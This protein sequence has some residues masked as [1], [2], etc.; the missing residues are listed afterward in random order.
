MSVYDVFM[1][2]KACEQGDYTLALQYVSN[3]KR[4]EYDDIRTCD[5]GTSQKA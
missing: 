5:V 4:E 3:A 1:A 2:D